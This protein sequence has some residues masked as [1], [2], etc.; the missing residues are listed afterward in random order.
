MYPRF[1]FRKGKC[2]VALGRRLNTRNLCG[3]VRLRFREW[4]ISD[5]N[6]VTMNRGIISFNLLDTY[7]FFPFL[8]VV[9]SCHWWCRMDTLYCLLW[10]VEQLVYKRCMYIHLCTQSVFELYEHDGVCFFQILMFGCN[11]LDLNYDRV[12]AL[13]S[14]PSLI[15]KA[16]VYDFLLRSESHNVTMY[17]KFIVSSLS[18]S[19]LRGK[20]FSPGIA[21]FNQFVWNRMC[22]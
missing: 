15:L 21:L 20:I 10:L 17:S 11:E 22:V 12:T 19:F 6:R 8:F 2:C 9:R 1:L 3:F 5:A 18:R 7:F 14:E 16:T 4:I 13:Q